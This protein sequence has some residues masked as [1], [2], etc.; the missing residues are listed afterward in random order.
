MICCEPHGKSS[1]QMIWIKALK[2]TLKDITKVTRINSP[3]AFSCQV[4]YHNR[5]SN[6]DK[7]CIINTD[8]GHDHKASIEHSLCAKPF[9]GY[10]TYSVF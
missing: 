9:A 8:D 10:F 4:K 1:Q 2:N 6:N 3:V 5:N 7:V